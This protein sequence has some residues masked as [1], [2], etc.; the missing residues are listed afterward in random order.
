M[1]S[2]S[3]PAQVDRP[4]LITWRAISFIGCAVALTINA[5]AAR[6][7]LKLCNGT[8]SRIG[9]AIGYEDKTGWSTEGW[10]NVPSQ[11][12]ETILRGAPPSRYLYVHAIDYDRGGEW[13]GNSF[14][15]TS[16]KSFRIPDTKDCEKRGHRRTG[17]M[18]VDTGGNRDWTVRFNDPE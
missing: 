2:N 5:D 3:R 8:S 6:A 14:M 15:C 7:D 12:C 1:T 17:F 9:V 18:E 10:W 4:G 16:D 13:S 11:S